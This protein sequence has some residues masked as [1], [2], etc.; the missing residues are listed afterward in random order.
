MIK[1]IVTYDIEKDDKTSILR[2]KT[3]KIKNFN[4]KE[5]VDCVQD[6]NDTLDNLI[7]IEGNKR[8]A[9]GLSAN[10][11]G[12]DLYMSAVTL[13]KKRYMLINPKLE[14]ENGKRRLFRIGCFSLYKYRAMVYYNDDVIISYY[15]PSGKKYNLHLKGDQ[16]CVV[17]HEMDHL[18]GDLLF[19]SLENKE[20]DL[21]I[22]RESLY[23]DGKVPK[24]NHGRV[25]E[26]NRKLGKNKVI[27]TPVYYSALFNDYTDYVKYVDS[28]RKEK[29]ALVK[30][31][32]KHTKKT[33]KILEYGNGTGALSVYLSKKNYKVSCIQ[34]DGDMRD[35]SI[36]INKANKAKVKYI[37]DDVKG[38]FSTAFSYE[39]LE[40]LDDD[41]LLEAIDILLQSADKLVFMVPTIEIANNTLKGNEHLRSKTQW[42]KLLKDYKLINCKELDNKAYLLLT[43]SK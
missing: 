4:A 25:F 40:T 22:P 7:A 23:K 3:R 20:C 42:L 28:Q 38:R 17:Q 11:I 39:V 1:P 21:F 31:I 32:I 14:K 30:E 41:M 6:L 19:E 2:N 10:Q 9:I 26:K 13:G 33:E 16:S 37:V 5:V 24:Q 12:V 18:V 27:P 8:G 34:L 29:D 35:L 15:D 36:R 43:I